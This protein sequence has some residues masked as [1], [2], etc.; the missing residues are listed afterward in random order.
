MMLDAS[1]PREP[2]G[3]VIATCVGPAGAQKYG[4]RGRTQLTRLFDD[5]LE[6]LSMAV[7]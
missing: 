1:L 7:R 5:R 6:A 3:R 2:S 4:Q